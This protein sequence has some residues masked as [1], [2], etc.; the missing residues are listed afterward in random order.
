GGTA[1][2]AGRGARVGLAES[3][4]AGTQ[5]EHAAFVV[6]DLETTGLSASRSRICEIGAARVR[7]LAVESTFETLVNPG[8]GLPSFVA[9]LTGIREY[10]LRRAPRAETG[11]R[12][13]LTFAGDAPLA[14]HNARFDLAFLDREVERL[15]G[16]RVAAPVVDTVWLARR[17]FCGRRHR[18]S[19]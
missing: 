11:P 19:R 4:E 10:E 13:F 8:I 2:F 3:R 16:R 12:R 18:C 5:L 7:E 1:R 17:P 15:T 6:F 9:E 14:A